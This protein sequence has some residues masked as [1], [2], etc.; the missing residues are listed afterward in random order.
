MCRRLVKGHPVSGPFL[1]FGVNWSSMV[2][3]KLS[4]VETIENLYF[5]ATLGCFGV[6]SWAQLQRRPSYQVPNMLVLRVWS[7]P[8]RTPQSW[9]AVGAPEVVSR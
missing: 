2:F 9:L 4:Q 5:P 6:R 8:P 1:T 7:E 3:P